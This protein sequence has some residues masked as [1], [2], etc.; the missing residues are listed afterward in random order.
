SLIPL[1]P[2]FPTRRSSD[3]YLTL[4]RQNASGTVK[5]NAPRDGA[6][7][8]IRIIGTGPRDQGA[9]GDDPQVDHH[10][11][12]REYP[13]CLHVRPAF[14]MFGYEQ[15]TTGIGINATNALAIITSDSGSLPN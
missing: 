11:V 5:Y 9:G 6:D 1:C 2:S 15:Q 13:A 14:P 10:V 7:N 8:Q 4:Q 3:L 12:G